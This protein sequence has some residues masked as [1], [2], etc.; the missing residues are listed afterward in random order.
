MQDIKNWS[1]DIT[2]QYQW[3][4][5]KIPYRKTYKKLKPKNDV[6]KNSTNSMGEKKKNAKIKI[7]NITQESMLINWIYSY[8]KQAINQTDN[9]INK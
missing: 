1:V 5:M 2:I 7:N 9:Q 8:T 4:A 3:K 6:R